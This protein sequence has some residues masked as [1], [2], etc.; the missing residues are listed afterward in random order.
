MH[1]TPVPVTPSRLHSID[2]VVWWLPLVILLFY[3]RDAVDFVRYCERLSS[4]KSLGID[5]SA[6]THVDG[7]T[8]VTQEIST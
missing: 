5:E 6:A 7:E 8:V 4:F 2:E 3:N 1:N